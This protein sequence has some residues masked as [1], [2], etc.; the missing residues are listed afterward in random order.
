MP[1]QR[2]PSSRSYGPHA[3]WPTSGVEFGP[4]IVTAILGAVQGA[5]VPRNDSHRASILTDGDLVVVV[6]IK[7]V[8]LFGHGTG[9]GER[10][11]GTASED[12]G[13]LLEQLG[14]AG[15]FICRVLDDKPT[16][17]RPRG[18]LCI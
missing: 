8:E 14:E 2:L 12:S 18:E 3:I 15:H 13:L 4:D 6:R 16:Y 17:V 1:R 11:G 9:S 10:F 5:L 7:A